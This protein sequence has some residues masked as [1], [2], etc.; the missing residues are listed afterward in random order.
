VTLRE[1]MEGLDGFDDDAT[2]YAE[3]DP[4]DWDV[5]SGALVAYTSEDASPPALP[6]SFRYLLEIHIAKDAVRVWSEWRAG[7]EPSAEDKLAAVLYYRRY[8]AFMP[9]TS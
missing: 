5:T 9:V 4:S 8:D 6:E 7:A 3:G 1:V 2:I